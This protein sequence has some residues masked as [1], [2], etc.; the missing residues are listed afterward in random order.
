MKRKMRM[1]MIGG[2]RGS[3]IGRVHHIAAILDNQ[4]ELVC[5]AFS[6]NPEI[7][8]ESGKDYMLP[9]NR[10][11]GDYKE[12]IEMESKLPENERMDWMP[13]KPSP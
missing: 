5:G 6:S 3:F 10:V 12:M 13:F 8:K 7:S 9:V 1:G 4:I 11:Y 2:G